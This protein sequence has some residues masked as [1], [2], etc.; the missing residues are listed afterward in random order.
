MVSLDETHRFGPVLGRATRRIADRLP[1]PRALDDETRRRFREPRSAPGVPPGVLAVRTYSEPRIAD[2][3]HDI[4]RLGEWMETV[5][6]DPALEAGAD[7]K[8]K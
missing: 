5:P 8:G 7:K 1:L 3:L 4:D 2:L 6:E